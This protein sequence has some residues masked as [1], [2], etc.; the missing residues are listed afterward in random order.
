LIEVLRFAPSPTGFLHV[1]GARTAIFNWLLAR[2][3]QGRFL[4]RIE[5][6][7]KERSTQQSID[8]IFSSLKWL[9]LDWDG[10]V[11][12]Q[13]RRQE[14]HVEIAHQLLNNGKAYRCFCSKKELEAKR[15][16]AEEKKINLR[17]DG[18]CRRLSGQDIQKKLQENIPYSIRL[19]VPEGEIAYRDIVHGSTVVLSDTLDDFIILRSDGS[20]VYQLA[21]VVD[22]HDLGVT[23]IMRGDDHIANTPKQI[24]IYQ[25]M[26]WAVPQFGHLPLILGPDKNRLSKRHGAASV[27]EFR[28]A[29]ILP[30]ALFNYLCLLGWSPGSDQE[31]F[32][33]E[34]LIKIF[35]EN[36]INNRSA[37][38]DVQ[39]LWWINGKYIGN[40]KREDVLTLAYQWL[41]V[42]NHQLTEP[43]K[44]RFEYLAEL[45]KSRAQTINELLAGLEMFFIDPEEYDPAGL[46]KHFSDPTTVHLLQ[47]LQHHFEKFS[48]PEFSEISSLETIIRTFA[49]NH[50]VPAARII[51]PLRLAL[52]GKTTGAGIFDTVYILGR[53][54]VIRRIGN[55]INFVK[56]NE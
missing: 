31:I 52:T 46:K 33:R 24:I 55:I 19:I 16:I 43:E 50:T 1:G 38:F 42:R 56:N 26:G 51:H 35:D 47:T 49:E 14:R 54:R 22:D 9:G 15:K 2:N 4:L 12:F 28:D 18:A 20:P 30:D 11:V 29:G 48:D 37:V 13:S 17:Y 53:E 27:E 44:K 3:T 6:T 23:K 21:V 40:L 39:K 32:S 45:T 25:A 36:R 5:D 34:D 10:D 8:Q 7:D 41:H